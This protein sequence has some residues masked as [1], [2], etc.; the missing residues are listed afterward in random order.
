MG[1]ELGVSWYG[2]RGWLCSPWDLHPFLHLH[3]LP[4]F[5]LS[6]PST[7]ILLGTHKFVEYGPMGLV[8]SA[9]QREDNCVALSC[10]EVF[11]T[12][13]DSDPISILT[14][15]RPPKI[16]EKTLNIYIYY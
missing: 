10:W 3:L 5:S 12:P 9:G 7:P 11:E 14:Q 15:Y 1:G 16:M 4:T 13:I 8:F 2:G 6:S